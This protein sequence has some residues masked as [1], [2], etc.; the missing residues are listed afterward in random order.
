MGNH[1]FLKGSKLDFERRT[2][3]CC[4]KIGFAGF[5]SGA[6]SVC[7]NDEQSMT[8]RSQNPWKFNDKS[9]QNPCSKKLCKKP[10]KTSQMESKREPKSIAN[11]E[12]T[13]SGNRCEKRGACPDLPGGSAACSGAASKTKSSL[14]DS[15]SSS[16]RHLFSSRL[17]FRLFLVFST[18]TLVFWHPVS[19]SFRPVFVLPDV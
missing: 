14:L 16:S 5:G 7:R 12:K 17:R 13:R 19:S 6:M 4:S 2:Q 11:Q 18:S 3:Y 15:F 8:N 1:V 10:D 9:M